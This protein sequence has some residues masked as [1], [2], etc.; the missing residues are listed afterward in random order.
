LTFTAAL[1]RVPLVRP[2]AGRD[3]RPLEIQCHIVITTFTTLSASA[4]G[5]LSGEGRAS[6]GQGSHSRKQRVTALSA[7]SDAVATLLSRRFAGPWV[8]RAD[9]GG[10][11]CQRAPCGPPAADD[12]GSR[13]VHCGCRA[14]APNRHLVAP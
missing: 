13:A 6:P 5:A 1:T 10:G 3:R 8:R 9:A 2:D 4:A 11:A 12:D 14:A 7:R